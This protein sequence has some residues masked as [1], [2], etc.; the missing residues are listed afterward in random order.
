MP[1]SPVLT[2]PSACMKV[3]LLTEVLPSEW[4]GVLP[5]LNISV[6]NA[7]VNLSVSLNF[8]STPT[9][10]LN[11][12]GPNRLFGPQVPNRP[13]A[14]VAKVLRSYHWYMS[15]S[16]FGVPVQSANWLMKVE[17]NPVVEA[18]AVNGNPER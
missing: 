10:E 8:R 18:V 4:C 2:M 17:F 15:P 6:R 11:I 1:S 16:F 13:L 3:P 12:V 9:L 7:A 14:G 5:R